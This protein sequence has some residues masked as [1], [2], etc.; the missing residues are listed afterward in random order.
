MLHVKLPYRSLLHQVHR[1]IRRT[2]LDTGA[3]ALRP[4]PASLSNFIRRDRDMF[5]SSAWAR[6]C[7]KSTGQTTVLIAAGTVVLLG[8]VGLAAD[9]GSLRNVRQH[10]QSAA[11]SAAIAAVQGMQT[12]QSTAQSNALAD[13]KTNGFEDGAD[14]TAVTVENPPTEGSYSGDPNYVRVVIR[15]PEP[16]RF[17]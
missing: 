1:R 15:Q 14:G 2:A 4:N 11:D 9:V 16:T 13:A 5:L 12:S 6:L 3:G 8:C 7:R 17:L 10:M